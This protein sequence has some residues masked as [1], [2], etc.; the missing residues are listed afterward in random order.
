[1]AITNEE[2]RLALALYEKY[3]DVFDSIYDALVSTKTIDFSTSD[4]AESK[5]RNT[6]RLAV[7]I[8]GKVLSNET[9][10]LLFEDVLQYIVDKD[11]V[12]TLPLLFLSSENAS[13]F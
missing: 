3:N 13:T 1:M 12:L 4:I 9:V 6:G 2:K 5:G 11:Y 8:D 10:R 7:K